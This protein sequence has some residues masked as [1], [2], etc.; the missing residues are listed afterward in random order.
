[1]VNKKCDAIN[2]TSLV[3]ADEYVIGEKLKRDKKVMKGRKVLNV[4]TGEVYTSIKKASEEL[5]IN[6]NTFKSILYF[7]RNNNFKLIKNEQL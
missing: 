5:N 3:Y 4:L 2:R 7:Q 6:Y 1:M